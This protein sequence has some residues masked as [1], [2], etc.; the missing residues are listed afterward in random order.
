MQA[1][2]V[3]RAT[4]TASGAGAF[5]LLDVRGRILLVELGG[6][7]HHGLVLGGVN[8]HGDVADPLELVLVDVL[9][10]VKPANGAFL[11]FPDAVLPE[12]GDTQCFFDVLG[13]RLMLLPLRWTTEPLVA[14]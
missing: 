6:L 8:V 5:R 11:V 4:S 2:P 10:V 13:V 1:A 14:H 12:L 9:V 7:L 3:A